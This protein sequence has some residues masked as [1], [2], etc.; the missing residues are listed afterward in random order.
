MGISFNASESILGVGK[1]LSLSGETFEL[2]VSHKKHKCLFI[3]VKATT[4]AYTV[5]CAVHH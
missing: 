5:H 2:S 4:F 3:L 1:M